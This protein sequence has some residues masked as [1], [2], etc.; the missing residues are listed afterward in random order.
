[1]PFAAFKRAKLLGL[2]DSYSAE[3]GRRA[4]YY[5]LQS[6]A[7]VDDRRLRWIV[8]RAA[9]VTAEKMDEAERDLM[10]A[11]HYERAENA[12][13]EREE[14]T[15]LEQDFRFLHGLMQIMNARAVDDF[16]EQIAAW[17]RAERDSNKPTKKKG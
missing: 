2:A 16:G 13:G 5:Y 3:D 15:R 7:R 14:L 6:V 11:E 9:E 4:V 1:M 8:E 10:L 12:A 17:L